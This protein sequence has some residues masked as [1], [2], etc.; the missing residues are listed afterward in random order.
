[1]THHFKNSCLYCTSSE[2][3]HKHNLYVP[4]NPMCTFTAAWQGRNAAGS[5]EQP[6]TVFA[7]FWIAFLSYKSDTYFFISKPTS[8]CDCHLALLHAS[9]YSHSYQIMPA[10]FCI[11]VP[12]QKESKNHNTR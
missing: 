6:N 8:C 10:L 11:L 3:L 4:R 12:N 9:A 5:S 1:M 7:V 2:T